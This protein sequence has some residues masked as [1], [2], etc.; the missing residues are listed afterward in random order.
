MNDQQQPTHAD[1]FDRIIGTLHGLPDVR[2][3]RPSTLRTV[4][5]MLG[6][7]QTFVIQTY[8]QR[9][10]GD[11]IFIELVDGEGRAR[12]VLPPEAADAIARQRDSL[13]VAAR[14]AHG[15]EIGKR[16][17]ADRKARGI[18]PFGGKRAKRGK[19]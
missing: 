1:A 18:A 3:A 6:R 14:K 15:R 12:I 9:E 8:R 16:V 5:P 2:A 13:T 4:T 17:S 11:F 7:S 19:R 10:T